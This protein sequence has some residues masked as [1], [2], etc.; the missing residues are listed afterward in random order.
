MRKTLLAI[1]AVTVL[2]A[3]VIA[4]ILKWL[5]RRRLFQFRL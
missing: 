2:E 5:R 3:G 1:A 4:A